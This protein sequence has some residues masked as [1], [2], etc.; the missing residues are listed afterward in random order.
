MRKLALIFVLLFFG[1][2]Q[3]ARATIYDVNVNL[4]GGLPGTGGTST[5]VGPC[6]CNSSIVE[7]TSPI[8]SFPS[9]ST[10]N[11]GTLTVYPVDFG[12]STPDAGPTQGN[13]YVTGNWVWV[14]HWPNNYQSDPDEFFGFTTCDVNDL[15]CNSQAGQPLTFHLIVTI[16]PGYDSIQIEWE[17]I[18][19]SYTPPVPEPSTWVTMLLG[20][21]GLAFIANRRCVIA[22]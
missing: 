19:F 4:P 15:A 11:F 10:I 1:V 8:Y 13:L 20:F 9:G 6:Y 5:F 16:P 22:A 21:A 7:V 18:S 14:D 12:Q 3:I 17:A 2:P